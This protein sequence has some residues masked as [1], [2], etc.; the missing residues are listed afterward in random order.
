VLVESLI[1]LLCN[2]QRWLSDVKCLEKA[3]IYSLV[4]LDDISHG[5]IMDECEE[6]VKCGC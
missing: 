3:W 6:M 2:Q 5:V 1:F 4:K